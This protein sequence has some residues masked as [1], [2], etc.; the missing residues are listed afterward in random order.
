FE[1]WSAEDVDWT[2]RLTSKGLRPQF[3]PELAGWH[4]AHSRDR[5]KEVESDPTTPPTTT[6]PPLSL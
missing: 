4:Q 1:R 3:A 6:P 5:V 2:F